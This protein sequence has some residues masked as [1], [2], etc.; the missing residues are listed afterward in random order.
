MF[1]QLQRFL[2]PLWRW[3]PRPVRRWTVRLIAPSYTVGANC[4][5]ERDDGALLL[6]RVVYRDGWGL[7][8]GLI[9]RR[10]DIDSCARREVREETGLA[11]EL[12]GEPA[13]VVEAR[14]QRI[15]VVYRAR[16]ANGAD[17]FAVK[18]R[19][20]EVSEVRWFPAN[21]LPELQPEAVSAVVALAR[22]DGPRGSG[23]LPVRP[24]G[25]PSVTRATGLGVATP[26][27]DIS[28]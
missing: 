12:V 13:V 2:L 22:S 4:L 27:A 8:G 6:V 21:A 23:P 25:S 15:D 18:P 20:P 14:P 26:P 3:V 1:V 11:V 24:I 7:P 19:S 28:D 17:A 16:P 9:N 5:I 10:E